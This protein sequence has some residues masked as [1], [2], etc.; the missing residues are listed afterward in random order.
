MEFRLL[1]SVSLR[2]SGSCTVLLRMANCVKDKV[3]ARSTGGAK[4]KVKKHLSPFDSVFAEA[5]IAVV[6]LGGFLSKRF[7]LA[8][9]L[10]HLVCVD[11][12]ARIAGFGSASWTLNSHCM[13]WHKEYRPPRQRRRQTDQ[14]LEAPLCRGCHAFT[15]LCRLAAALVDPNPCQLSTGNI[16]ARVPSKA[17]PL[18]PLGALRRAHTDGLNLYGD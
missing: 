5:G 13:V 11:R 6:L 2:R 17:A 15:G 10:G 14:I 4:L 1:P 3:G 18:V 7:P 12:L 8:V 9:C 16:V